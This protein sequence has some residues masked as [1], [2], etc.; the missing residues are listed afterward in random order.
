MKI[1]LIYLG[2]T[3]IFLLSV[4]A[5]SHMNRIKKKIQE[6]EK[7]QIRIENY[8]SELSILM[9]EYNDF[10][11]IYTVHIKS[12]ITKGANCI[13]DNEKYISSRS[14]Y[15]EQ[16]RHTLIYKNFRDECEEMKRRRVRSLKIVVKKF[17]ELKKKVDEL[18]ETVIINSG[19]SAK[20]KIY[21]DQL[22]QDR[23]LLM[24]L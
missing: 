22:E 1:L 2:I 19:R 7:E 10:G 23:Q 13:K 5:D 18:K 8:L 3:T 16:H 14:K 17:D 20:I 4:P 12:I 21:I 9:T 6:Y 15:G 11:K 24:S